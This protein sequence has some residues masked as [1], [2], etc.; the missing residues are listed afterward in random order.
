MGVL[1]NCC[2]RNKS[3]RNNFNSYKIKQITSIDYLIK[4]LINSRILIKQIERNQ[5]NKINQIDG[6]NDD[7]VD[8]ESKKLYQPYLEN[9]VVSFYLSLLLGFLLQNT[10]NFKYIASKLS[11]FSLILI[12]LKELMQFQNNSKKSLSLTRNVRT[13]AIIARIIQIVQ[14][15]NQSLISLKK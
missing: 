3:F 13:V 6:D 4:C 1:I 15:R 2:E 5:K 7:D 9:R 11:N 8:E 12:C 10:L 14:I